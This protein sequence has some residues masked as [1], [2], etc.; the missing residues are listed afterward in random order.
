MTVKDKKK[1]KRVLPHGFIIKGCL[2]EVSILNRKEFIRKAARSSQKTGC[3][4]NK[5]EASS[6]NPLQRA[7]I[8]D[9]KLHLKGCS[10][11]KA[12]QLK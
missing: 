12:W 1:S 7:V 2:K 9:K 4:N 11:P 10:F 8:W 6:G 5:G 3:T